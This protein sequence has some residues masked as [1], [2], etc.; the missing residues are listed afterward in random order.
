MANRVNT[1]TPPPSQQ[2]RGTALEE[3]I[4]D[5]LLPDP[6]AVLRLSDL[7]VTSPPY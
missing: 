4:V 6:R 5:V 2:A 1:R 7:N 3:G